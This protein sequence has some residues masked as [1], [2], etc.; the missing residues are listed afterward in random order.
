VDDTLLFGRGKLLPKRV[1]PRQGIA[2]IFFGKVGRSLPCGQPTACHDFWL[3]QQGAHLANHCAFDLGGGNATQNVVP[4]G[5][6]LLQH[7]LRDVV[8][9]PHLL[10]GEITEE[11]GSGVDSWSV[12]QPLGVVAGITPFNFPVMVPLWMIPVAL[13][14]GNCFILKPSERD[15]SAAVFMAELLKQ[16]GLPDGVFG[17]VHGDKVAVDAILHHPDIAAVT[18]AAM[19]RSPAE[20]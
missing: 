16:A 9:I 7:A 15:P 8:A 17:V 4:A 20:P 2:R 18:D 13:T 11:V 10:K 14:C 19:Q 1:K 3:A 6:F 5:G 12:R